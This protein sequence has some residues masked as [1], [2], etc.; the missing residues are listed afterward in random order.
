MLHH[1]H[2]LNEKLEHSWW[3]QGILVISLNNHFIFPSNPYLG[4]SA[5]FAKNLKT[6]INCK[7]LRSLKNR[8]VTLASTD[9]FTERNN[10]PFKTK[11]IHSTWNTEMIKNV[12][13]YKFWLLT[14]TTNN[15]SEK[16]A[17]P[18]RLFW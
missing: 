4:E 9:L 15:N 1:Y 12:T 16:S 10:S 14:A 3:Q 5:I 11:N 8:K 17:L 2:M 6:G 7:I 13:D 18:F